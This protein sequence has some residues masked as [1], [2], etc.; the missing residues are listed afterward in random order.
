MTLEDLINSGDPREIKRALSVKMFLYGSSRAYISAILDV[1]EAFVTKWNT[2]YRRD[3]VEGLLLGYI[4]SEGYLDE[5]DHYDIIE[6][7]KQHKTITVEQLAAYITGEY[8]VTYSS[9]QSYY[10][11]LHEAK[12]SWKKTEKENPKKDPEAVLAKRAEITKK[13]EENADDIRSGEL[14][15]L[16]EDECHLV[17]G[18][19]E[20]YV[21]G[22]RG[23][24]TQVPVVNEKERQT[25]Y[26]VI[27]YATHE[28]IVNPYD[29]GNGANTVD[30]IKYLRSKYDPARMLLIWDGASYHKFS[31]MRDYLEAVNSGL[32]AK[33]WPVTCILFAPYAPEQNPVEDIW[34][35][36]KNF[37]RKNFIEC[38]TFSDVKRVFEDFLDGATFDFPKLNMYGSLI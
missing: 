22:K 11:L 36:G 26:G 35:K 1:T 25:Y 32:D 37:I 8:G 7:I 34:L 27:N 13:L 21:W 12:M 10:D 19:I 14:V 24:P 33:D 17:W 23:E 29:A 6:Y 18:D 38:N 5:F 4:G 20:G 30:F 15:V 9:R 2:I 3:G 16:I 31:E 28:F